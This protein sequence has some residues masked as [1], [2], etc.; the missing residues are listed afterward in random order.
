[1][2]RLLFSEYCNFFFYLMH[3]LYSPYVCVCVWTTARGQPVYSAGLASSFF[4]DPSLQWHQ[5]PSNTPAI[6]MAPHKD[7]SGREV[8]GYHA[9]HIYRR[10]LWSVVVPCVSP[11]PPPPLSVLSSSVCTAACS[12]DQS[13]KEPLTAYA[14]PSLCVCFRRPLPLLSMKSF[15]IV[16]SLF[17]FSIFLL[18]SSFHSLCLSNGAVTQGQN[19]CWRSDHP[20]GFV[21]VSVPMAEAVCVCVSVCL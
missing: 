20:P 5:H 10:G 13:I 1:M 16:P 9:W 8:G 6:S 17:S 14:A 3:S 4:W 7:I 15:R 19:A 12:V 21:Q 2:F 11:P 18:S